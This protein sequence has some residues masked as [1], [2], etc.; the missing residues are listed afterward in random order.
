[1][2][3][4]SSRKNSSQRK[5]ISANE[6]S[7]TNWSK[8]FSG[9]RTIFTYIIIAR[10]SPCKNSNK[11][12]HLLSIPQKSVGVSDASMS[13]CWCWWNPI[14]FSPS[15]WLSTVGC[16]KAMEV[17]VYL[18]KWCVC[19]NGRFLFWKL[20]S[21]LFDVVVPPRGLVVVVPPGGEKRRRYNN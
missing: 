17:G 5:V 20:P 13:C 4:F 19:I 21:P 11:Y 14:I 16:L 10:I 12:Q 3:S 15:T 7:C 18:N 6:K 1:M 2:R 9:N 8:I